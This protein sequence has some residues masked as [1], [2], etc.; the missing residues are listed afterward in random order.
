MRKRLLLAAGL[1]LA[2]TCPQAPAQEDKEPEII[3]RLKVAKV[4]GP[5]SLAV[6][7]K[8]NEGEEKNL[9]KAAGPCVAASRKE[10]GCQHYEVLQ[11]AE[12]PRQFVFYERWKSVKD[13]EAHFK[14]EHFKKLVGELRGMV[15]GQPRFSILRTTD[16]E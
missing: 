1:A 5:F 2:L 8:V 9:V 15:D 11:D 7:L 6:V 13:L 10:K 3:T 12:N 4:E 14:T 16:K